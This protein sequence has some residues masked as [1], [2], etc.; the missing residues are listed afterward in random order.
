MAKCVV[1]KAIRSTCWET[2]LHVCTPRASPSSGYSSFLSICH[3]QPFLLTTSSL[4]G[5]SLDSSAI[6][7]G[8]F[9]KEAA[10]QPDQGL[11]LGAGSHKPTQPPSSPDSRA[12]APHFL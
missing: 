7:S 3:S 11:G 5:C 10:D 9:S 2:I 8:L 12:Q 6:Q 4:Q 1:D